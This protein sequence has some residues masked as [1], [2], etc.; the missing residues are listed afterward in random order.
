MLFQE[1]DAWAYDIELEYNYRNG[2]SSKKK[3]QHVKLCALRDALYA[4]YKEEFEKSHNPRSFSIP[5]PK[6]CG[7]RSGIIPPPPPNKSVKIQ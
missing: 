1:L 2:I 6:C 4:K 3:R 5:A 7:L